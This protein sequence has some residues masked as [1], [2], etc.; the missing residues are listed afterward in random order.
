M[1]L[2][3]E[4]TEEDNIDKKQ[5]EGNE[6][7]VLLDKG[8]TFKAGKKEYLIKQPYL[9][10][11]D[12]LSDEYLKLDIDIHTINQSED[13]FQR[14]NEQK[15]IIKPNV[16]IAAKVV[17][18]AVLNSRWKIK[19]LSGIYSR[20]FLWNLTPELLLKLVEIIIQSSN[21]KD[22][23]SSIIYL[24]ISPRTTAPQVIED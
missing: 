1:I 22:F 14:F 12:Y 21:L 3:D 13:F 8:I 23:T 4:F 5:A 9:G 24:S 6:L 11:L 2:E 17:A 18:I 7:K 10:T 15:R 16:K 20:I 19:L